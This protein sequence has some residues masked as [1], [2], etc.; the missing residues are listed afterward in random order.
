MFNP[1]ISASSTFCFLYCWIRF[2]H[3]HRSPAS[4]VRVHANGVGGGVAGARQRA[5][6]LGGL[7]GP[8][9]GGRAARAPPL[10]ARPLR[11]SPFRAAYSV[12]RAL[13]GPAAHRSHLLAQATLPRAHRRARA[14]LHRERWLPARQQSLHWYTYTPRAE[15][16][17]VR[18]VHVQYS[19]QSS[20]PVQYLVYSTL[21]GYDF[22][23][24]SCFL[25]QPLIYF[26]TCILHCLCV[27]ICIIVL[28]GRVEYKLNINMNMQVSPAIYD[29]LLGVNLHDLS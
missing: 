6:L 8:G 24:P 20:V 17:T 27:D 7:R 9:A 3:T 1:H 26:L 4:V 29:L 2:A 21:Y 22:T 25:F 14:H 12:L 23:F 5:A 11:A 28:Y 10:D 18:I 15:Y 13:P 19:S 16:C